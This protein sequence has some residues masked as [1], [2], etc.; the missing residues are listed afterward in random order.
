MLK[1]QKYHGLGNDFL[2][3]DTQ[4][5]EIN[6]SSIA[7]IL[8]QRR[9]GVGAD[10]IMTCTIRDKKPFMRIFNS[11]GS[12]AEMCGNGLRCFVHHLW[13]NNKFSGEEFEVHTGNGWLQARLLEDNGKK[14]RVAN[15]LGIPAFEP[16]KIPVA[17]AGDKFLEEKIKVED[18]E[19]SVSAVK[20]GPPHAV[21]F[22]DN[23]DQFPCDYWG[24]ILEKNPVFPRKAN[25][26]FTQILSPER[27]RVI[28]WERGVGLTQACGTGAAAVAVIGQ[29]LGKLEQKARIELPG[30]T[31]EIEWDGPGTPATMIG[32]SE[33]VFSG[34]VE[35]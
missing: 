11:D 23:L 28:V 34:E 6:W 31:L 9:F 32:D 30:G 17:F 5:E 25:I 2:I 27:A 21:I 26:N 35:L 1:F 18:R 10:G 19:F 15:I 14:V 29:Q 8:C 4:D 22:L 16:E 7:K 20:T 3:F 12:E 13:H 33:F 24:P